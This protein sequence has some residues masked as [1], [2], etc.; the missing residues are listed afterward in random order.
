[1]EDI[2]LSLLPPVGVT[3]ISVGLLPASAPSS[4]GG[5]PDSRARMNALPSN[6][7]PS[8]GGRAPVSPSGPSEPL[9]LLPGG[10]APYVPS[11][12]SLKRDYFNVIVTFV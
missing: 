8:Q 11:Q 7:V 10:A 9:V 2:F 1:M 6:S 12:G 3:D 5:T 4:H